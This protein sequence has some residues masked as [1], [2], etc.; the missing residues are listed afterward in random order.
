MCLLKC[1]DV[2]T[3]GGGQGRERERKGGETEKL[4]YAGLVE[5]KEKFQSPESRK[6]NS[7]WDR[8]HIP[9]KVSKALPPGSQSEP[10]KIWFLVFAVFNMSK[11]GV[12]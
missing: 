12:K 8:Y 11:Q 2:H 3:T 5:K 6:Q 9:Q 1:S 10:R 4:L 7:E